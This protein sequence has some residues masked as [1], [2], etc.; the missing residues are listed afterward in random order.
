M[1][2][3]ICPNNTSLS[4]LAVAVLIMRSIVLKMRSPEQ[5]Y[6]TVNPPRLAGVCGGSAYNLKPGYSLRGAG[7]IFRTKAVRR[8]GALNGAWGRA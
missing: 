4:W 5:A 1:R 3:R 6:A 7:L 2:P 8:S